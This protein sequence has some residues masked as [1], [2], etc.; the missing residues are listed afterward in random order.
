MPFDDDGRLILDIQTPVEKSVGRT[1]GWLTILFGILSV[2]SILQI[3][4]SDAWLFAK[5]FRMAGLLLVIG[6]FYYC[7]KNVDCYYVLDEAGGQLLYHFSAIIMVSEDP[8]ANLE[9]VA[10][11]G[12]AWPGRSEYDCYAAYICLYDGRTI[13][14]SDSFEDSIMANETGRELAEYLQKP[15]LPAKTDERMT[16][17]FEAGSL[18][19]K[20]AAGVLSPSA[21]DKTLGCLVAYFTLP[22]VVAVS[23]IFYAAARMVIT[24]EGP[25]IEMLLI[26]LQKMA[27]GLSISTALNSTFIR[28]SRRKNWI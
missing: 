25:E 12:V 20:R 1:L 18:R 26:I 16:V 10:G 6:F 24:G 23:F 19:Y 21:S 2:G 9:D 15:F 4:E 22:S 5:V 7:W 11:I 28:L 3:L 17:V 27:M 14:I 13:R 8:V